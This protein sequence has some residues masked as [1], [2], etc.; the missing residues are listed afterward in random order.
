[1][2][3]AGSLR[4]RLL[5]TVLAAVVVGVG[6][7][8]LAFNVVLRDRLDAD[9]NDRLHARAAAQLGTLSVA[10][11]RLEV[12]EAPDDSAGDSRV[13]I[14]SGGR[15]LEQPQRVP[16]AVDRAADA[17]AARGH[18]MMEIASPPTSLLAEP[19]QRGGRDLGTVVVSVSRAPYKRTERV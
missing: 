1:M 15:T 7:L 5:V 17:V 19:I 13:W 10:N 9:V 2:S 14:F 3:R 12:G 18:G 16:A 4:R 6:L 8:T 11:G